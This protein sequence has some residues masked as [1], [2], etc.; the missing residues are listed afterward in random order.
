MLSL[1]YFSLAKL[2]AQVVI[3]PCSEQQHDRRQ[4]WVGWVGLWPDERSS[5][6]HPPSELECRVR[7]YFI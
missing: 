7:R 3:A 4:R 6:E 2:L 5:C 1:A